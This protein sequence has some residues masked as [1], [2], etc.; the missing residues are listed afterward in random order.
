MLD[1][2]RFATRML[3]R[4]KLYTVAATATLAL[5][6]GATTAVFSVIDATLLRPLPYTDPDRLLFVN[7]AQLDQAGVPQPLP[8]TQN[9]MLRWREG[10]STLDSVEGVEA[11][12]VSLVG[13]GEPIVLNVGAMT[14][15]LFPALGVTPALGRLFTEEEER[16]DAGLVILSHALWSNRFGGSPSILGKSITLGG[17]PYAVIG[18]MPQHLRVLFDRSEA[19]VPMHPTV[20]PNRQNLRVMFAIGRLRPG[21]TL[22]QAQSELVKLQ[23]PV[24][25]EFAVGSGKATPTVT[26]LGER[27]FGQRRATLLVL[28]IAV[29]GLLLLASANVANLT[30]GHLTARQGELATRALVGASGGRILRL[31]LI[32]TSL[33]AGAGGLVGLA[34]VRSVLPPLVALY[35]GNGIGAITLEVDWRVVLLTVLIVAGTILLCTLVP[36]LKIHGAAQRGQRDRRRQQTPRAARERLRRG[37]W[38]SPWARS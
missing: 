3:M 31:L 24:A 8:I 16:R 2:L 9:E 4:F 15:G 13:D 1:D 25:K 34:G 32:Q 14:S 26:L 29:V 17:R 33:V 27:L 37:R 19:W 11:Q 28:G 7:V 23:V 5:A 18:V 35:N 12:T 20:D 21:R 38:A 30:L 6:I 22:A 10:T 36:A